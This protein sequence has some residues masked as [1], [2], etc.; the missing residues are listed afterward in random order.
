MRNRSFAVGIQVR[1]RKYIVDRHPEL[2]GKRGV[3]NVADGRRI[4]VDWGDDVGYR[5][6]Y[7]SH[8][9]LA[10]RSRSSAALRSWDDIAESQHPP[11]ID[12]CKCRRVVSTEY[13][14]M[15]GRVERHDEW[16]P[17]HPAHPGNGVITDPDAIGRH[18]RWLTT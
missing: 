3:I 4:E 17:E 18:R 16:C 9:M 10:Q 13:R 15:D 1:A 2:D 12:P 11:V 7:P 5:V 6:H 14:W 8:L